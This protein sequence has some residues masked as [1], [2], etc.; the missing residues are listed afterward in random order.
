MSETLTRQRVYFHIGLPKTGTT[1]FQTVLQENRDTLERFGL[2]VI[3]DSTAVRWFCKQSGRVTKNGR[4][5]LMARL[6][7]RQAARILAREVRKLPN[8]KVLVS[9]ENLPGWRINNLYRVPFDKGARLALYELEAAFSEFDVKW[10][11]QTRDLGTHMMSAYRFLM[12]RKG[13]S[14][15]FEEWVRQT[16]STDCLRRLID[17]TLAYLGD[18]TFVGRMEDEI[19]TKQIWGHG[20]FS[21]IGLTE[22]Q[23]SEL[24]DVRPQNESVSKDLLPYI[25]RINRMNLPKETRLQIVKVLEDMHRHQGQKNEKT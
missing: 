14:G 8:D 24:Q 23:I 10:I 22:G 11:L 19:G 20:I 1:T 5:D 16:G 15:S 4:F 21:F 13:V 12:Q 2:S 7:M 18:D 3:V 9:A 6:R 25:S 17:D